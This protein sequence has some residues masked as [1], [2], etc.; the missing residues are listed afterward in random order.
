MCGCAEACACALVALLIQHATR[1]RQTIIC[2]LSGSTKFLDIIFFRKK[3]ILNTKCVFRFSLQVLFKIFLILK[4]I[5]RDIFI[6]VNNIHVKYPL[7]LSNFNETFNFLDRFSKNF[8]SNFMKTCPVKA[9][10]F[11]ADGRT[12]RWT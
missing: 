9:K 6:N 1:T 10:L 8:I 2:G 7:F 3:K 12:G 5:Q 4:E 11:H